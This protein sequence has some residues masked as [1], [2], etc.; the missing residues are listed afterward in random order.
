MQS[1][2]KGQGYGNS[3]A[4]MSNR[5]IRAAQRT[6]T[7]L[8]RI[9]AGDHS[10]V[11]EFRMGIP[12]TDGKK[13]V[14]NPAYDADP[15]RNRIAAEAV[16]AHEA[17]G[18]L[19][20]TNF[21]DW[22]G[23]IDQILQ[24][25]EDPIMRDMVNI[26]EDARVNYLLRQQ[27]PGSGDMM[28]V[29]HALT[30]EKF[31]E[32][33]KTGQQASHLAPGLI[34]LASEVIAGHRNPYEGIDD[35][36]TAF[37]DEVRPLCKGA[38]S[39][40]NTAAIIEQSKVITEVYRKHFPATD[41]Q[42]QDEANARQDGENPF[43]DDDHSDAQIQKN[44]QQQQDQQRKAQ[45]V[46]PEEFEGFGM[47]AP[48]QDEEE[49]EEGEGG[50]GG[51]ESEGEEEEESESSGSGGEESDEEE[52]DEEESEGGEG[53]ESDESEG[54]ESD[55][56]ESEGGEGDDSDSDSDSSDAQKSTDLDDAKSDLERLMEK[57][58][59][60][61]EQGL[62][63]E[64]L[65]QKQRDDKEDKQVSDSQHYA[66]TGVGD[67]ES[68]AHVGS[69]A[70]DTAS[71]NTSQYDY[72]AATHKRQVNTLVGQMKRLIQSRKPGKVSRR[73]RIGYLDERRI[74]FA[75]D[76]D[77]V[78]KKKQAPKTQDVAVSVVI[79]ESGSMGGERERRAAEMAVVLSE[80]MSKL[81]WNY[82][83]VG[84]RG[85]GSNARIDVRKGFG[86]S[87]NAVTKSVIAQARHG[88]CTPAGAAAKWARD[89]LAKFPA[90]KKMVFMIFDGQPDDSQAL[91]HAIK[92]SNGMEWLGIGIDGCDVSPWFEHNI[93]CNASELVSVGMGVIRRMTR[94]M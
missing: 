57:I 8:T 43:A 60:E 14:L 48:K 46:D 90:Q 49:S 68:N 67:G 24:G 2:H 69:T 36:V 7:R 52:V 16:A 23:M 39:Q 22:M 34:A 86:D 25:N 71:R 30:F 47:P 54:D 42:Q 11:V 94:G 38:I 4:A 21:E 81:G 31:V 64:D 26:F 79:D 84:F 93:S 50:S 77:R 62:D 91:H 10:V 76:T 5:Q 9:L 45:D 44:A 18:H 58:K 85:N 53:D 35:Q 41:S 61:I 6:M 17:A 19:R 80:M 87:L 72:Y 33:I 88:Q 20:F 29:H 1:L 3:M 27:F 51:E 92:D 32:A 13:V 65:D 63:A 89:R 40:P 83:I 28:D 59:E 55:S 78:Y 66:D 15:V 56:E 82:E 12:H 37:M 70:K 73:E 75:D 74:V